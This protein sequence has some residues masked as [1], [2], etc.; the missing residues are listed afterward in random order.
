MANNGQG[1]ETM[2][3]LDKVA[4]RLQVS[5]STARR[6]WQSDPRFP[7]PQRLSR[8]IVRWRPSDIDRFMERLQEEGP[9]APA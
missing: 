8:R 6:I 9:H 7:S 4:E 1:P 3:P 5:K 2:I